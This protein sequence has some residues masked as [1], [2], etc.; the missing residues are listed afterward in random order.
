[1]TG[2]GTKRGLKGGNKKWD[3]LVNK[4][5]EPQNQGEREEKKGETG[6]PLKKPVSQKK[7]VKIWRLQQGKIHLKKCQ[8][9]DTKERTKKEPENAAT[10]NAQTAS[11]PREGGGKTDVTKNPRP[12]LPGI[13]KPKL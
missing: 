7:T 2:G 5:A 9:C 6:K 8:K 13:E 4:N 11:N 1:M 3:T 10:P 12:E